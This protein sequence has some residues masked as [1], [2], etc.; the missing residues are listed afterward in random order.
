MS[1]SLNREEVAAHLRAYGVD[2]EQRDWPAS[3][4]ATLAVP[5]AFDERIGYWTGERDWDAAA[6]A[7]AAVLPVIAPE[8][9]LW[10]A[11][12]GTGCLVEAEECLDAAH[13]ALARLAAG[14][15][16]AVVFAG[17]TRLLVEVAASGQV[18]IRSP[19]P[20]AAERTA[21]ALTTYMA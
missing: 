2:P 12:D 7:L 5:F 15:G 3:A 13:R 6:R 21:S 19:D 8:P 4:A 17:D 20:R 9:L 18:T 10:I 11:A 14:A 1:K 16:C